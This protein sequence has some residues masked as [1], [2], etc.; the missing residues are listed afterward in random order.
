MFGGE[1]RL[2]VILRSIFYDIAKLAFTYDLDIGAEEGP[3][4]EFKIDDRKRCN[5]TTN[6]V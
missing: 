4:F 1:E 3:E 2:S 5:V 6:H